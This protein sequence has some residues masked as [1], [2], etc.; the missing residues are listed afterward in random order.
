[1]RY[2]AE[3]LTASGHDLDRSAIHVGSISRIAATGPLTVPGFLLDACSP[4]PWRVAGRST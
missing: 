3:W 4:T 1:M 2:F